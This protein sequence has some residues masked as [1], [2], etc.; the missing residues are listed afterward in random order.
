MRRSLLKTVMLLVMVAVVGLPNGVVVIRDGSWV[1]ERERGTVGYVGEREVVEEERGHEW[2]IDTVDSTGGGETSDIAVDSNNRPHM[3]YFTNEVNG[4]KYAHYDGEQWRFE[5]VNPDNDIEANAQ[6]ALDSNNRPHICYH[7]QD[8]TNLKYVYYDGIN[9]NPEMIDSDV[10]CGATSIVVDEQDNP[11]I[12]YQDNTHDTVKYAHYNGATWNKETVDSDGNV[13]AF[14]SIAIDYEGGV[15]I[16]YSEYAPPDYPLKYAYNDGNQWRIETVDLKDS[17]SSSIDVD[18]NNRP[19]I[20]YYDESNFVLKYTYY[21]G[22]QWNIETVDNEPGVGRYTSISLDSQ[23]HVHITYIDDNGENLKYAYFNGQNWELETVNSVGSVG[24]LPSSTVDAYDRP[25]ISYVNADTDTLKYAVIPD[26]ELPT[27]DADNSQLSGTTGDE[28]HFNISASDNYDVDSVSVEWD[29]GESGENLPLT[30]SGVYWTGSITLEHS[31]ESLHYVVHITDVFSNEYVSE[32]QEIQVVDNDLPTLIVD[33]TP[34]EGTTGDDVMFNIRA[35]DNIGV[36]QVF[37]EWFQE[38]TNGMIS[39]DM[40]GGFWFGN[41]TLTHRL[42]DFVYKLGIADAAGNTYYSADKHVSITD[43]DAPRFIE[44]GSDSEAGT[45]ETFNFSVSFEDNIDVAVVDVFYS[46][47]GTN[48]AT[49]RMGA[50]GD[51][52]WN[53]AVIMPTNPGNMSYRFVAMDDRGNEFDT[54]DEFGEFKVVMVD[55]LRPNAE[56]GE[57]G[58]I[59]QFQE[60]IFDGSGCIDNDGIDNYTWSFEYNGSEQMLYGMEVRHR[61]DIAGNYTVTLM[62]RDKAGNVDVDTVN[63]SVDKVV[64]GDDDAE[65]DVEPGDDDGNG[66]VEEQGGSGVIVWVVVGAVAVIAAIVGAVIVA[67]VVLKKG[68]KER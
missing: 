50:S 48:Y 3:I 25:H 6:I 30:M 23:D 20:S 12:C 18:N 17:M 10:T 13:G 22:N 33:E 56:A 14:P 29:H 28:F 16:C 34:G 59:D 58:K 8:T 63:V 40:S 67:V 7:D 42:E 47:D 1:N 43:N 61:F 52:V 24:I 46:F 19:H 62:V 49:E 41:I 60:Y 38:E 65:D 39:L 66:T 51:A 44:D 27:L 31:I 36:E 64:V 21:D 2:E 11:H 5:Y 57:A 54:F 26:S 53:V 37:V 55:T 32:I 35:S 4:L 15:H 9:W 45:S 68:G